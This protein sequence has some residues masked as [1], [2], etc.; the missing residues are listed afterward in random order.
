MSL[1]ATAPLQPRGY[2]RVSQK[3]PL[4][5]EFENGDWYWP[6]GINMRDGGDDASKQK[7]TY[8]FDHYFQRFEEE[9]LNFV[10]TWMCAWWGGIEWSDEYHSRFDGV[11]R[12][13]QYNAWRLD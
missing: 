10:R 6:I 7:G 2:V 1:T 13:N 11:G 8:D 12:Y 5:Y 3:D 9:G 4:Y